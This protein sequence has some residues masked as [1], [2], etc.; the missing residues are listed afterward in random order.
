MKKNRAYKIIEILYKAPNKTLSLF[1][2]NQLLRTDWA[3]RAISEARKIPG[4][5]IVG[6]NPYTL[7]SHP[8]K[9]FPVIKFDPI[10]KVYIQYYG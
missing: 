3:P 7:K 10:K 1:Q 4:V 6:N 9:M 2:L 5:C 8:E